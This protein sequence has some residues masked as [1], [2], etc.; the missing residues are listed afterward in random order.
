M[1]KSFIPEPIAINGLI[2]TISLV[3]VF[4]FLVIAG[5]VPFDIVWGGRLRDRA[6]MLAFETASIIINLI[7]L[8]IISIRAGFIKTSI[9]MKFINIMIGIMS[10]L[11]LLNTIGNLLSNNDLEKLIF[12]PLTFIL[13]ILTFQLS[14][15]NE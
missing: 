9:K 14:I 4:H 6:Q 5:I 12:T 11:F 15:K 8:L 3:I 13:F 7:M 10:V 2:I 1:L